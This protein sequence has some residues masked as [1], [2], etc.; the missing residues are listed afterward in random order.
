RSRLSSF[1]PRVLIGF[2][3][4]APSF[5]LARLSE[6]SNAT[7]LRDIFHNNSRY[8]ERGR[9]GRGRRV[10]HVY[11]ER[12]LNDHKV[13][14]QA[15]V[16]AQGLSTDPGL[17]RDKVLF[18]DLG[19]KLLQTAHKRPLAEGSVHLLE[20]RPRVPGRQAPESGV[21]HRVQEIP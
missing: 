12:T 8:L 4:N 7:K 11:C 9:G 21:S 10:T 6:G 16:W 1:F 18:A 13:V 3:A 14:H 20:A 19:Y 2:R 17:S 5:V 15:S